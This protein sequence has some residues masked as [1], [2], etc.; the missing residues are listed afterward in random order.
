MLATFVNC[1]QIN[2]GNFVQKF[3]EENICCYDKYLK[4]MGQARVL[5]AKMALPKFGSHG[6]FAT[7]VCSPSASTCY[8]PSANPIH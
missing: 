3:C 6:T 7:L 5:P 8:Q 1:D 2:P 4:K